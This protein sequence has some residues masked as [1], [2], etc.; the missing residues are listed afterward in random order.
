MKEIKLKRKKKLCG[1]TFKE[2][3]KN[4]NNIMNVVSAK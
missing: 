4:N 2:K 1:K 3:S